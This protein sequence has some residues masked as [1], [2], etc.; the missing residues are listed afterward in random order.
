MSSIAPPGD[1]YIRSPD[2]FYALPKIRR[3]QCRVPTNRVMVTSDR[4]ID[5]FG[6]G[7]RHCRLLHR[8]IGRS[9]HPRSII[10]A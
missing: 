6:V 3:R 7:K 9:L 5:N 4:P 10:L 2:R 1:G 8:H